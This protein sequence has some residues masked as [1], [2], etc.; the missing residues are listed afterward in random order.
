MSALPPWLDTPLRK[1][2]RAR[3]KDQLG[4]ALLIVAPPD[5]GGPLLAQALAK[6]LLCVQATGDAPACNICR[7]CQQADSGNHPDLQR[8]G[9]EV[10][11][12]TDQLRSEIT[13]EQIRRL[14]TWMGLTAQRGG[15]LVALI[16]DADLLNRSAANALLKTLEE[17]AANRYLLLTCSRPQALP[18]TIRSRCQQILVRLPALASAL[19]W[20]RAQGHSEER[21]RA[22]LLAA[23]G[24]PGSAAASLVDGRYELRQRVDQQLC[25]LAVGRVDPYELA[26]QWSTDERLDD[27]LAF[28]AAHAVDTLIQRARD[29]GLDSVRSE[30]LAAWYRQANELR[31]RLRTPARADLSLIGLLADW[32][33]VVG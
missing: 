13:I 23:R 17:P 24:N 21:A 28:A 16:E 8:V 9:L 19:N 7:S 20:L 1:A 22:A 3:A 5:M 2:C 10:N 30:A 6:R 15:A 27:R 29:T 14:C 32:Q 12:R 26:A 33:R 11:Q 4:H 18:A 25:E 31:Q